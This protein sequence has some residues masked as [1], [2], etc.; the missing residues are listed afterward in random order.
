MDKRSA[1]ENAF[2]IFLVGFVVFFWAASPILLGLWIGGC[3]AY[4]FYQSKEAPKNKSI[5][6]S[7][8]E[9]QIVKST[10]LKDFVRSVTSAEYDL[11]KVLY[12]G[13]TYY[14][15]DIKTKNKYN[16]IEI[17]N[18]NQMRKMWI[19]KKFQNDLEFAKRFLAVENL[20]QDEL[21]NLKI[22]FLIPNKFT[23]EE[24]SYALYPC[25]REKENFLYGRI[26]NGCE[27]DKNKTYSKGCYSGNEPS[28]LK[29]FINEKFKEINGY[30]LFD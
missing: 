8:K 26:L 30:D 5:S 6:Q 19:Q 17:N 3:L 7:R 21:Q 18:L 14:F 1:W 20:S 13:A 29:V 28:P 11:K 2:Y 25:W 10:E 23:Q 22:K 24:M 16:P 15:P 27:V 4:G 9:S 12:N